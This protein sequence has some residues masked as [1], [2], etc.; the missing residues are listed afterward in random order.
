ME[1]PHKG[2]M[3]GVFATF[4]GSIGLVIT[5]AFAFIGIVLGIIWIRKNRAM[6]E[7]PSYYMG[8]SRIILVLITSALQFLVALPWL[9]LHGDLS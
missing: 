3:A 9:L 7:V 4:Y 8:L 2:Y 5:L 1:G 6:K